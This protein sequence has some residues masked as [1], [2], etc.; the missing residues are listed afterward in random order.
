MLCCAW[1]K[2]CSALC[3]GA[4]PTFCFDVRQHGAPQNSALV[5]LSQVPPIFRDF[6]QRT[7]ALCAIRCVATCRSTTSSNLSTSCCSY[8][9]IDVWCL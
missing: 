2:V 5:E 7:R 8:R 4:T 3:S 9:C 1:L 6:L